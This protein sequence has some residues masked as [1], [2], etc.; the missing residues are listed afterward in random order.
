[1]RNQTRGL[2]H[3]GPDGGLGD[4]WRIGSLGTLLHIGKLVAQRGDAAFGQSIRYC[5]HEWMRRAGSRAMGQQI[6]YARIGR[7][8]QQPRNL[9]RVIDSN[10]H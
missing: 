10:A 1:M 6:A 5:G 8:L 9:P 4:F 2:Q 3:R 7:Y